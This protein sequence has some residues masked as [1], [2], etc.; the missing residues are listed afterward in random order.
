M[1]FQPKKTKI[2]QYSITSPSG[3]EILMKPT[4]DTTLTKGHSNG[5]KEFGM[6]RHGLGDLDGTNK[7][8]KYL[9]KFH[10]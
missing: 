10:S 6:G 5:I 7:T 8:N 4:Q 1:S 9:P 2:V 3:V